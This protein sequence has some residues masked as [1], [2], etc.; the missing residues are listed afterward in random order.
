MT[1]ELS[2][3]DKNTS[4]NQEFCS[5]IILHICSF[6]EINHIKYFRILSKEYKTNLYELYITSRLL[7]LLLKRFNTCNI[8]YIHDTGLLRQAVAFHLETIEQKISENL[9]FLTKY[10]D[11]IK[12]K[13]LFYYTDINRERKEISIYS[14]IDFLIV[15]LYNNDTNST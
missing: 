15:P 8:R 7:K 1:S 13:H 4:V 2:I 6:A 12:N 5:D 11:K 14:V 9:Y 3:P 10:K